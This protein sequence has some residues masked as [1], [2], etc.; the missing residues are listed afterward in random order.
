[1]RTAEIV[2]PVQG[3]VTLGIISDTEV[4]A[5]LRLAVAALSVAH[6]LYSGVQRLRAD[7]WANKQAASRLP[8]ASCTRGTAPEGCPLAIAQGKTKPGLTPTADD[9]RPPS[10]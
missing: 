6:L 4:D 8:F 5:W 9:A 3:L 2:P 10:A 7:A 1:M